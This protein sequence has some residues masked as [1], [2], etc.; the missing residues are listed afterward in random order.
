M[1]KD[2]VNVNATQDKLFPDH[3]VADQVSNI[4]ADDLRQPEPGAE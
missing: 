1:R 4:Q 3:E 2:F